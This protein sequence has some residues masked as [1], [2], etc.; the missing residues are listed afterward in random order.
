MEEV[1]LETRLARHI[2]ALPTLESSRMGLLRIVQDENA[3]MDALERAVSVDPAVAAKVVKI[4][5]S[6][7]YR[8]GESYVTL[9]QAIRVIGLDMVKCVALSVAVMEMFRPETS[10]MST[11][12]EHSHAVAVVSAGLGIAG[13]EKE[14]LF[15]G[16]LL[17]DI[18]RM[19]FVWK[20]YETYRLLYD[21]EGCWPEEGLEKTR[22]GTMHTEV[23]ALLARKWHFPAKVTRIIASHHNPTDRHSALVGLADY[24]IRREEKGLEAN[25]G[26]ISR[27]FQEYLG[28]DY[29]ELVNA[30]RDGY[31]TSSTIMDF[32]R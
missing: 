25:E 14:T 1:C 15:T 23:G 11:L 9:S 20:E 2:D 12:W 7:F 30:A 19:V 32:F 31:R 21:Q 16:G 29:K 10:L 18:G 8:H 4:A 26:E 24:V 27:L 5:N 6:P 28:P 13:S 22:F 17:H 3:G